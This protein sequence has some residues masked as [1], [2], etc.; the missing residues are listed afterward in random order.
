MIVLNTQ[1]IT[2][3][4]GGRQVLKDVSLTLQ[5]KD[6]IGLVGV[7]GCGKTTL[8]KVLCGELSAD[9]G[10]ISLNRQLKVGYLAQQN[11]PV[12][13]TTVYQL[14]DSVFEPVREMERKLREL[15]G[16]MALTAD[17]TALKRLGDSYARLNAAFEEAG[18]YSYRSS[19][20]GVFRGLGF[21]DEM[22]DQDTAVLSGGELTRLHLG[23]LLLQQPDILLL[24][25]PTNHLDLAALEWLEDYL[26]GYRGS[27]LVVSHDRYF[28]DHVCTGIV[29]LAFGVTEQYPG[30]YSRYL[31]LR[32]ER[33]L[34]RERAYDAQQK[35]I[36]RQMEIIRKLR[37]F[38]RE[39]SIKRAESRV[40]MLDKIETLERPE[41]EKQIFFHFTAA[42]RTGDDVLRVRHLKKAFEGREVLKDIS[43]DLFRGD[44]VALIGQNGIGKTTLF[45]CLTGELQPDSGAVIQGANLDIG[46]YDQHQKGLHDEKTILDEI[47]DDFPRMDQTDVRGALGQ[48][49]FSGEEVFQKIGLLS[50][51][52]KGRVALTRLMLRRD[53][54]LLLDEPTNHL[55][56]NSREVLEEALEGFEGTIFAI[57]HDRYFINRF[58]TRVMELTPEGIRLYDG[59]YDAYLYEKEKL[60]APQDEFAQSGMTRTEF[61]KEK[62]RESDGRQRKKALKE[63]V[64]RTENEAAQAE[65]AVRD[66]EA[67]LAS[68]E[69][70]QH[71]EDA[72]K[73]A[74][75]YQR[76][77]DEMEKAYEA[78]EAAMLEAE[79]DGTDA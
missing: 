16:Q 22:L 66:F 8:L 63:S 72:Q 76:L 55:D 34:T 31:D 64:A 77:R 15:E 9:G 37:A 59:N 10:V 14:L 75:E 61:R 39:K 46:Y 11:R 73:N 29:E 7:N 49:L 19:I 54:L 30:N 5:T 24:D 32:A 58:A 79:E 1:H 23:R 21:P 3:A 40:K 74:R 25:E 26:N 53:N 42:R 47:W 51:G 62:R 41:E 17:E 67:F 27:V 6:R 18:G 78:W 36:A 48:F 13:G 60:N 4:F 2:K 35:E 28:M 20:M 69:A 12:P 65:K 71:P 68:P 70:Y 56:M 38:N 45:R 52:E 33:W 57:S 50:G 44:R 43:F